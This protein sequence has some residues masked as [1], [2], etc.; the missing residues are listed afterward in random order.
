MALLQKSTEEF[1]SIIIVCYLYCYE[2]FED[3]FPK[4]TQMSLEYDALET[5]QKSQRGGA[6]MLLFGDR[7]NDRTQWIYDKI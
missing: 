1:R 2:P 6:T 4:I 3:I 5:A 7:K